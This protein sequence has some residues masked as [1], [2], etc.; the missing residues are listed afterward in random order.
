MFPLAGT[1][2]LRLGIEGS[3]VVTAK[4]FVIDP[5]LL[6]MPEATLGRPEQCGC[7]R[8]VYLGVD[9]IAGRSIINI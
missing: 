7:V 2:A 8:S 3:E 9:R 5:G 6:I 1:R 4:I